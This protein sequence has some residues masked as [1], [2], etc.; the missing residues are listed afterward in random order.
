MQAM[1]MLQALGNKG[2][3]AKDKEARD[4][5][6]KETWSDLRQR[7]DRAFNSTHFDMALGVVIVAN[8]ACIIMETNGN[9]VCATMENNDSCKSEAIFLIN[10]VF[11]GIY[12]LEA[13]LRIFTYRCPRL[14]N[15]FPFMFDFLIVS[16]GYVD[17]I[18]GLAASDADLPGFAVLRI[19]RI[20][21]LARAI[22]ILRGIPELYAMVRSFFAAMSAMFWGFLIILMLLMMWAILAVETIHPI[23][24]EIPGKDEWCDQAFSNVQWCMLIF[25]QTLV[26]G[27]SWGTCSVKI[28]QTE[29][30]TFFIFAGALVTIQLG[31]TNLILAVI[32]E[33][34]TA[35]REEDQMQALQDS[36]Q[37]RRDAADE[38]YDICKECDVNEDSTITLTDLMKAHSERQELKKAFK[39]LNL[40]EQDIIS[41][42]QTLD[43][44]DTGS[45]SY[46][47]FAKC[48]TKTTDTDVRTQVMLLKMQ[49]EEVR[50]EQVQQMTEIKNSLK[51]VVQSC[52]QESSSFLNLPQ[53]KKLDPL[54]AVS[55]GNGQ[56][57]VQLEPKANPAKTEELLATEFSLLRRKIEQDINDVL[58]RLNMVMADP[59]ATHETH[60]I[61]E[62]PAAE[63]PS[64]GRFASHCWPMSA[65][66]S[67]P[68]E[69]TEIIDRANDRN[70]AAGRKEEP[71]GDTDKLDSRSAVATRVSEQSTQTVQDGDVRQDKDGTGAARS[72]KDGK[73]VPN[74]L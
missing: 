25:F 33:K 55:S 4:A 44:D 21:R 11:L 41:L 7:L 47:Q 46:E 52:L 74:H 61:E 60:K 29:P 16:L 64:G 31:F 15:D 37:S 56:G 69:T 67:G 30:W 34:A 57:G 12:T 5:L 71:R 9:A 36:E 24:V 2:D 40:D 28:I 35:V 13:S 18:L 53:V 10:M 54:Q 22:R 73:D 48:L 68:R 45:L 26:A 70:V 51:D 65:A 50:K 20:A 39:L 19:F 3:E 8:I 14:L 17:L 63:L 62:L 72:S 6:E 1:A 43:T 23:N 27:D 66:E 42:F 38:V 59:Y 32:V 58:Q 49:V